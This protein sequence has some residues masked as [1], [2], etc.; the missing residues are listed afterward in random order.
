MEAASFRVGMTIATCKALRLIP[1]DLFSDLAPARPLDQRRDLHLRHGLKRLACRHVLLKL[2]DV[3]TPDTT[4]STS[5][6]Q[7]KRKHS[8]IVAIPF[9]AIGPMALVFIA[10]SPS[11]FLRIFGST[12]LMKQTDYL[13]LWCCHQVSTHTEVDQILAPNGSLE[14]FVKAKQQGKARHIGFTGHHDPT[15]HQRLLDAYNGAG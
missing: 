10:K 6:L 12:L 11:P 3:S 2:L 5:W 15:V 13:D 14:A 4:V 7:A 9:F 1:F 8:G